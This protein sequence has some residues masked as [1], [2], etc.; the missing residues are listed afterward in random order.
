M[1]LCTIYTHAF[2]EVFSECIVVVLVDIRSPDHFAAH[3][4][5]VVLE[6]VDDDFGALANRPYFHFLVYYLRLRLRNNFRSEHIRS[7]TLEQ[8][9][10]II[11]E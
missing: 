9:P 8:Y 2:R 10:K 7:V 1:I 4:H 3:V 6:E 11:I 5:E